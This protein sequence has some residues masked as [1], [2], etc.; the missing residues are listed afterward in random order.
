MSQIPDPDD[1]FR[2]INE[3]DE[4]K[5]AGDFNRLVP[6]LRA[7]K[8][9]HTAACN[10]LAN[11]IKATVGENNTFDRTPANQTAIERAREKLEV[12]YEKLERC[13]NRLISL[14]RSD[15]NTDDVGADYQKLQ[16]K[17]AALILARGQ[18]MIDM[19]PKETPQ[20]GQAGGANQN[21]KPIEALKP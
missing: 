18:L 8:S 7:F 17:H 13:Y 3:D 16:D 10:I 15:K 9:H 1:I 12:R 19:L 14:S 20:Q 4:E 21:L 2:A 11:L 6:K 5:V